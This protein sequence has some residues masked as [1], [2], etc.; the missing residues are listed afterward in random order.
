MN[1]HDLYDKDLVY[2]YI[3][4]NVRRGGLSEDACFVLLEDC[5]HRGSRENFDVLKGNGLIE[6]KQWYKL[7][8]YRTTEEGSEKAGQIVSDNIEANRDSLS[9]L[10]GNLLPGL[11]LL[12]TSE[13]LSYANLINLKDK[14]D[15]FVF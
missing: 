12:F 3:A 6:P 2:V 5:Y 1:G 8:G 4:Q 10:L 11:K 7:C 13:C 15:F 9:N 14:R